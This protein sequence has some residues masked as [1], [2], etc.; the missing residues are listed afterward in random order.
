MEIQPSPDA[1]IESLIE[2]IEFAW[3]IGGDILMQPEKCIPLTRLYRLLAN[4]I[5]QV[6]NYLNKQHN[7]DTQDCS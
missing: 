2:E 6:N 5:P 4:H 7:E 3:C 1:R